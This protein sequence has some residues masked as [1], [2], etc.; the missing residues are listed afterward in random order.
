L[1]VVYEK[2][3]RQYALGRVALSEGLSRLK[4]LGAR[5][6]FVETDSYP[7][8]AFR[9]YE[10]FDFQVNQNVLIYRKVYRNG[11]T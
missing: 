8:T 4:S 6:I 11:K 3:F 10:T 7:N 9:L 5:N 2:D 1:W